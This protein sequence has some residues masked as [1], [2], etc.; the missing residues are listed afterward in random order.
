MSFNFSLK[1]IY[2]HTKIEFKT[3]SRPNVKLT[4][5]RNTTFGKISLFV[6]CGELAKFEHRIGSN[7]I[8]FECGH[9][10][11]TH[12]YSPHTLLQELMTG[13]I[14]YDF[15]EM[16]PNIANVFVCTFTLDLFKCRFFSFFTSFKTKNGEKFD[17]KFF[18]YPKLKENLIQMIEP[19]GN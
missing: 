13:L 10:T 11:R 6:T 12:T 3:N 7:V 15:C 17:P 1:K 8:V 16:N 4:G 9:C 2:L 19:L 14:P 5:M 18:K